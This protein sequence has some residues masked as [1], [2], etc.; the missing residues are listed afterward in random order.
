MFKAMIFECVHDRNCK[1]V[2]HWVN[3]FKTK[4][5]WSFTEDEDLS[6]FDYTYFTV[7]IF[8]VLVLFR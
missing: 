6:G 1:C 3:G 5:K 2:A 4:K 7:Q 8:A